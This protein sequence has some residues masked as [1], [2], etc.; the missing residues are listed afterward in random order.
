MAI[1][2]RDDDIFRFIATNNICVLESPR[3]AVPRYSFRPSYAVSW[4][5]IDKFRLS[6]FAKQ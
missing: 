6:S 3:L 5:Q 1:A 4:Q 2:C